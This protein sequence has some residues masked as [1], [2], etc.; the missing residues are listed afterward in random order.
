MTK[1]KKLQEE[2]VLREYP[3]NWDNQEDQQIIKNY[4]TAMREELKRLSAIIDGNKN[5]E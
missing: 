4:I 3:I 5:V 2:L 1:L